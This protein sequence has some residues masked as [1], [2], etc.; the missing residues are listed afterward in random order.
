MK[1]Y[2]IMRDGSKIDVD[3]MSKEHLRNVLKM[4]IRNTKIK[5]DKQHSSL[6]TDSKGPSFKILDEELNDSNIRKSFRES[7][8]E[9]MHEDIDYE[10]I[11]YY[12]L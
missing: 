3:D 6:Q 11:D 7:E 1:Y 4:L 5:L 9:N 10:G 8:I 2:W 12:D